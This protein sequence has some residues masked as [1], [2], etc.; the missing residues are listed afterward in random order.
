MTALLKSPLFQF[1]VISGSTC[2]YIAVNIVCNPEVTV[3][4][5]YLLLNRSSI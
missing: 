5:L 3:N 2:F 4:T 1:A